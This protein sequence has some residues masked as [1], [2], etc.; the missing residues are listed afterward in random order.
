MQQEEE[1]ILMPYGNH[2][3]IVIYCKNCYAEF[4]ETANGYYTPLKY[5]S[6]KYDR[7]CTICLSQLGMI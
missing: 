1:L 3:G 2:N 7:Y 4:E 5:E 6:E